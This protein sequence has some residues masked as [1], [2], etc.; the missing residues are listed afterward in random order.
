M[1]WNVEFHRKSYTTG[2][3]DR[4][5]TNMSITQ[6]IQDR[7]AVGAAL[8]PSKLNTWLQFWDAFNGRRRHEGNGLPG[9]PAGI[10]LGSLGM[11]RLHQDAMSLGD[12]DAASRDAP[13]TIDG[14]DIRLLH[15]A[16]AL[17][18][19]SIHHSRPHSKVQKSKA[20]LVSMGFAG[21]RCPPPMR[22]E[23]GRWL[24]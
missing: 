5:E 10:P 24:E 2:T 15:T 8:S 12:S 20:S 19:R 4:G 9:R 14:T 16:L 7:L 18:C 22:S 6:D 3:Q 21:L 11:F 17:A 1:E 23:Y 13:P